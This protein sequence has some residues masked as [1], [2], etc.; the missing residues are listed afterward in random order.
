MPPE[1]PS[2]ELLGRFRPRRNIVTVSFVLPTDGIC[3]LIAPLWIA[4]AASTSL[5]L[6]QPAPAASP[7]MPP[8]SMPSAPPATQASTQATPAPTLVVHVRDFQYVP[9]NP[10]VHVGDTIQFVNDDDSAHTVTADDKSY[11]SGYLAK[12][13]TWSKTYTVTGAYPYFCAFHAFM[14]A[15]VTVK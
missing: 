15:S 8:M 6:A 9:K 5:A 1:Q 7:S 3:R 2:N 4:L 12:G 11:D 10:V 14:R 13:Q